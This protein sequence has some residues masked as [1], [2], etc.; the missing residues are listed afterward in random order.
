MD[1]AQLVT[2]AAIVLG[3]VITSYARL[4]VL[5]SKVESLEQKVCRFFDLWDNRDC[6]A[7]EMRLKALED[8]VKRLE[9]RLV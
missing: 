1:W 8:R 5:G 3:G 7:H 2:V 6:Q 9:E 4:S